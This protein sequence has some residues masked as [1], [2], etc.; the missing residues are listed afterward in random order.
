MD[1]ASGRL[2]GKVA[3]ISEGSRGMGE[4]EARRFTTEGPPPGSEV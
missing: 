1:R 2:E 3:L 4:A